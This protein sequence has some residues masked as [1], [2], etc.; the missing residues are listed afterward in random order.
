MI[1]SVVPVSTPQTGFSGSDKLVHAVIYGITSIFVY[2]R[3]SRLTIPARAFY[4]S[5]ALSAVYGAAMEL[6]Q[7]FLP[8]RSFSLGDITANT[9][10]AF[11][12]SI[13]YMK[14]KK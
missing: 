8:Y 10:G 2:R 7:Y 12:G 9:V 4:L 6:I 3:C 1:A 11:C 5:F 14:G 13:L